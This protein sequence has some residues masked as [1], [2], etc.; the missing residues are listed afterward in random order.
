MP[1]LAVEDTLKPSADLVVHK[2]KVLEGEITPYTAVQ[3]QIDTERRNAVAVSHTAT[4]LLHSGLRQV[5]GTHV[6][7][8][9][10]L[11][12]GG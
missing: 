1:K 8:A 4:H 10:S 2:C 3:A 11:V 5:L 7:Q 6:A 9:G 12:E